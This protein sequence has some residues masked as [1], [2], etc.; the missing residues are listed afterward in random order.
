MG[1]AKR[2]DGRIEKLHRPEKKK[3]NTFECSNQNV[4]NTF[5]L[6]VK[7]FVLIRKELIPF[8]YL[9]VDL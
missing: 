9:E 2:E 8:S 7:M 5:R 6:N 4:K 3:M 1:E